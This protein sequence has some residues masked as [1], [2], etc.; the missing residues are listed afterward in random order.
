MPL[1]EMPPSS[2]L[3]VRYLV[4]LELCCSLR[5]LLLNPPSFPLSSAFSDFLSVLM[6]IAIS[7][8]KPLVNLI[9]SLPVLLR[10]PELTHL[11][12]VLAG[13]YL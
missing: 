1:H 6:V 9:L 11:D 3:V 7:P 12:F 13:S 10:G 2:F 4:F 5:L 8:N